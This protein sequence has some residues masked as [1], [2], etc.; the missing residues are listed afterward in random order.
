MVGAGPN[1]LT[2]AVTL[3]R[4]GR[5]VLVL[6]AADTIGGGARSAALTLPGYVHDVCSAI[7]P[8]GVGSPVFTRLP[9]ADHGLEWR[10]PEVAMAHPLEGAR[11]AV[12]HRSL[13][14]TGASL[15]GDGPAWRRLMDPLVTAWDDIMGHLIRPMRLPGHPVGV[16]RLGLQAAIPAEWLARARFDAAPARALFAG[17]AAHAVMPI[18]RPGTAA[19]GLLLGASAHAVGWPVAAGGSQAIV[20]ALASYLV[21]LGG[22]VETGREVR[23]LG[24]VPASRAVLFDTSPYQ[25]VRIA[26]DQLPGRYQRS[27]RRF[28]HGPG[29]CK[30]DW[31][32]DGPVPWSAEVCRRAGTVHVGG[33]TAEVAAAEAAVGRGEHPTAPFVLVAQQSIVDSTRAPAGR[34][35]LWGYCHVPNGSTVDMTDAIE[36]QIERFAP[37]FRDRVL[38]QRTMTAADLQGYN[39]NYRGGDIAG[40]AHD[41]PQLVARPTLRLDPRRTPNPRLLLCSAS[42]PPGAGVHGL[43]GYHAARS[44]LKGVLR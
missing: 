20:D 35:T 14:V 25:M 3:A 31:A 12:L 4:A 44:A 41:L 8:L 34:H 33:T 10:H 43:C 27:L 22:T 38:A 9:L 16:A 6:E 29:V 13:A 36:R 26:G 19:F 7:H 24:D 40:G 30:V 28:R 1:G 17:L 2:A 39:A 42:T 23:T 15:D 11:A 5:S 21:S 37:G 32:L 18:D